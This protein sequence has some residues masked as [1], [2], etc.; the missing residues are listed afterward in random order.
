[1]SQVLDPNVGNEGM[2]LSRRLWQVVH[3]GKALSSSVT[4]LRVRLVDGGDAALRRSLH[5]VHQKPIAEPHEASCIS[6]LQAS[7]WKLGCTR[8]LSKGVLGGAAPVVG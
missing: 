1:M 3:V 5:L 2:A 4:S 6:A 7:E 8:C